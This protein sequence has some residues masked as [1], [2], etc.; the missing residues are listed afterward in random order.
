MSDHVFPYYT[1]LVTPMTWETQHGGLMGFNG[2]Y[3]GLI[4]KQQGC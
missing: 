4:N 1:F 2:D 3:R